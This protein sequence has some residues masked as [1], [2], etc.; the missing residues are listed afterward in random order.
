MSEIERESIDDE[1][2]RIRQSVLDREISATLEGMRG[3]IAERIRHIHAYPGARC[4]MVSPM[5]FLS[6][7]RIN[8]LA[9]RKQLVLPTPGLQKGFLH[10]DPNRVAV[11]KWSYVVRSIQAN[12]YAE[13]IPYGKPDIP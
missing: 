7:V 6:Q 10:I 11:K 8:V 12:Q 4:V 5:P 1:K 13:K 2:E 9:D 3:K